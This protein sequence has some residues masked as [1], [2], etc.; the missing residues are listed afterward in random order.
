MIIIVERRHLKR[1]DLLRNGK[2]RMEMKKGIVE[3]D[4]VGGGDI[5]LSAARSIR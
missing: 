3:L 2:I 5:I 1:I 4:V